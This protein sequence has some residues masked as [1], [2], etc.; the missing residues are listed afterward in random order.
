MAKDNCS[1]AT[2]LSFWPRALSKDALKGKRHTP[3]RPGAWKRLGWGFSRFPRAYT[4]WQE[5]RSFLQRSRTVLSSKSKLGIDMGPEWERDTYG[6]LRRCIRTRV[7]IQDTEKAFANRPWATI[8]DRQLFLEGWDAG[9]QF[10][11]RSRDSC[12]EQPSSSTSDWLDS[13]LRR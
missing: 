10:G 13:S 4:L 11:L 5:F 12:T 8:L 9:V 1:E 3:Y 6:T 2:L 7:R